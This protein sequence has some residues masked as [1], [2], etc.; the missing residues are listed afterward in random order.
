MASEIENA[1]VHR[2]GKLPCLSALVPRFEARVVGDQPP[3]NPGFYHSPEY[4]RWRDAVKARAGYRCEAVEHGRR[5]ER[6]APADRL[7]A[8]HINEVADGGDRYDVHNGQ[9]LCH[10]HHEK[11]SALMRRDRARDV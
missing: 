8:D 7:Y 3:L 1:M 5:C 10:A 4:R 6:Q 9:C 2:R 11:K